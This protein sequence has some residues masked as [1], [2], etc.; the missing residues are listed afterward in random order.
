M[1]LAL[2][3]I[4]SMGRSV[5]S[6]VVFFLVLSSAVQSASASSG[7]WNLPLLAPGVSAADLQALWDEAC[8]QGPVSMPPP[9]YPP[10][11]VRQGIGGVVEVEVVTNRCGQPRRVRIVRSSGNRNLDASTRMAAEDW[12]LPAAPTIGHLV[13][14]LPITFTPPHLQSAPCPPFIIASP[15]GAPRGAPEILAS[16]RDM[17]LNS[18]EGVGFRRSD[19]F[20]QGGR[21]I[22]IAEFVEGSEFNGAY[23][24]GE[25]PGHGPIALIPHCELER[26]VCRKFIRLVQSWKGKWPESQCQASQE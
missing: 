4:R 6:V 20:D 13:A 23:L 24:A 8:I 12:V 17:R 11:E 10:Q 7:V 16:A 1:K 15:R 22:Y 9:R 25:N 2:H 21:A 19:R 26:R 18:V 5:L 14:K 3:P